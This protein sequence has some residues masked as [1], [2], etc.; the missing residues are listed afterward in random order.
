MSK[1]IELIKGAII[2]KIAKFQNLVT[3]DEQEKVVNEIANKIYRELFTSSMFMDLLKAGKGDI[4]N[5]MMAVQAGYK[6]SRIGWNGINMFVYYVP[7]GYYQTQTDVAKNEFG[8]T[9]EYRPY[10]AIKNTAN[11]VSTWSPSVGD[12]LANDWYIV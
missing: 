3:L 5:A 2:E 1:A 9:V 12:A 6:V 8:P 7:G 11:A 4:G 10:L